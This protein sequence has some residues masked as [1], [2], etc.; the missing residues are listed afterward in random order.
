M[1]GADIEHLRSLLTAVLPAARTDLEELVKIP[2]ISSDPARAGEVRAVIERVRQLAVDAGAADATVVD[3]G[4]APALIAHWPAP[5]DMPTVL[6]Y[7]HADVQP[8]GPL[9]QWTSDPFVPTEREG[10]LF[11]RGAADDKAGVA[12]HLAVLR[13][14][15]G[16]PPVG[17]TLFIE[18]EEEIGSPTIAAILTEHAEALQSD[19]I[20]IADSA[21]T[22]VDVPAFTTSLRGLVDLVVEVRTAGLAVHSGMYGG[23]FP[24]A[25]TVLCR[26]LATLH[27][28]DGEVAVPGL[29]VGSGAPE[30]DEAHLRSDVQAVPGLRTIGS[31]CLND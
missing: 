19:V 14:F 26:L 30:A 17:V 21:N 7:A 11:G 10:R 20:V 18:G 24:D 15:G 3:C 12:M 1:S 16:R 6:L 31:G 29:V 2:S 25:I 22:A 13:A 23:V 5:P 8:T 9:E 27:D 28:D 4:G